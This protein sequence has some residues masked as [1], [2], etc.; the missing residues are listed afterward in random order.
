MIRTTL[1]GKTKFFQVD[2]QRGE[3]KLV[4]TRDNPRDRLS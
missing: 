1:K 3:E 2:Y 4:E